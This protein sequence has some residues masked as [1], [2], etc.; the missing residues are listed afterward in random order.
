[1]LLDRYPD[2]FSTDY[3]RNRLALEGLTSIESKPL[4]N[5]IAGYIVTLLG[6]KARE[7]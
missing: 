3:R 4:K 5:K 1:M 6:Q 2:K 7:G